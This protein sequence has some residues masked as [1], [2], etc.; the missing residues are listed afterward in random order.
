MKEQFD[1]Q[2]VPYGYAH[3]F[4]NQC[5]K[6]VNCLRNI[7]AQNITTGHPYITIINP[8]Y[9]NSNT[10]ECPY[11]HLKEKIRVAWGVSRLFDKIP[12]RDACELRH[13]IIGHFSRSKYYRFYRKEYSLMPEDQAFIRKMFRKKG[14]QE[15][16]CFDEYTEIYK[17]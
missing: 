9:V 8:A 4:N 12:Y 15:E 6:A 10:E 14:V 2:S 13:Q 5:A 1:Y 7:A 16:P 11:F 3:C 17:W